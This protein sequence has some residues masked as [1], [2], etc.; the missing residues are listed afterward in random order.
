VSASS[1]LLAGGALHAVVDFGCAA[2]GD[3]ACGWALWKALNTLSGGKQDGDDGQSA[4]RRFGWRYCPRQIIGRVIA[5][6]A[7]ATGH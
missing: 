1:L 3:P 6:H 5:D 4:A 7:R 2:A